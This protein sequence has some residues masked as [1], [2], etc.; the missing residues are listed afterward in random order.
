MA[1]NRLKPWIWQ[2]P[3]WPRFT[4][5]TAALILPLAAARRAQGEV[6]GMAKLLD[7][8]ADLRVQLEVLTNEGVATAAIEGEKFD[9]N[10]LRS[11]LARRLDLPTAGL[12]RATRSVEGLVDVLLDATRR[13]CKSFPGQSA[14]SKCTIEP[15]LEIVSTRK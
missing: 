12:S 10:S 11:L 13:P 15:R 1:S 5:D 7:A 9:P 3:N 14:T 6:A 4:W 2:H 8:H